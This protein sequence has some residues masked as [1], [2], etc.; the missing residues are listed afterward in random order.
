MVFDPYAFSIEWTLFHNDKSPPMERCEAMAHLY[1]DTI[2]ELPPCM[3][4]PLGKGPI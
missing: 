3:P 4:R 2:D 1:P